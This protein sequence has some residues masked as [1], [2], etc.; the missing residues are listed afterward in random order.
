MINTILYKFIDHR[1]RFISS[2]IKIFHSKTLAVDTLCNHKPDKQVF[3]HKR[4]FLIHSLTH[5]DLVASKL[6]TD[7]G[8]KMFCPLV[9]S[10]SVCHL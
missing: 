10:F 3:F 9:I 1:T 4:Q 8:E 2:K 5:V 6:W 7:K